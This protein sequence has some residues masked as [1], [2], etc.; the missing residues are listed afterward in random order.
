MLSFQMWRAVRLVVDPGIHAL[1]WSREEAQG[2]LRHNTAMAEHEIRTE[3]DRYIAWP[4]QATSYYLGYLSLRKMREAAEKTL[5][6]QFDEI[7]RASC[8]ERVERGGGG[9]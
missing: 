4:G 7:G 6:S 3:V 8:R 1:G 5:G 9:G 2:F